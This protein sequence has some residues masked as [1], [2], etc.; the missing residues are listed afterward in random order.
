M[1]LLDALA[2]RWAGIDR[3]RLLASVL[4]GGV[5]VDGQVERDP[6]RAVTASME[7]SVDLPGTALRGARKLD[8]ALDGLGLDVADLCVLDA[9]A[10]SG[11]FCDSLLRHGAAA[12]VCVDVAY[13]ALEYRLRQDPRTVVME[14]TNVMHL[15]RGQLEPA[16]DMAVCDL[17]FRSLRGAAN[18]LISLTAAG[19]LLALAKPQFEWRD[20]PDDFGGVVIGG[21]L[22]ADVLERLLDDLAGEG[23]AALAAIESA[24]RGRRGNREVFLLLTGEIG[25][26]SQA[27]GF[28]GRVAAAGAHRP[29]RLLR[30]LRAEQEGSG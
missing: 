24:V 3:E 9:G 19:R 6:R 17:S 23:V 29:Q 26:V 1:T 8:G 10:A 13:G 28:G 11:G 30:R 18:H 20:A 25:Q 27:A 4:G 7:L 16:P 21:E 12:V 2:R 22:I 14:R 15:S 5:S